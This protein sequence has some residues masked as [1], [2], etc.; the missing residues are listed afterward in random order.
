MRHLRTALFVALCILIPLDLYIGSVFL[1]HGLPHKTEASATATGE[2][3][4]RS[5]PL[6]LTV[7]DKLLVVLIVLVHFAVVYGA[8]WLCLRKTIP[9]LQGGPKSTSGREPEDAGVV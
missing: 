1:I 6:K 5:V 3:V 2:V 8:V 7:V 4:V 9:P